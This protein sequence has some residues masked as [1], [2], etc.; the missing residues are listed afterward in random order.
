MFLIHVFY[1][2]I[3]ISNNTF[4]DNDNSKHNSINN[5]NIEINV[6]YSTEQRT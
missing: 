4:Y 1:W 5:N 2:A 6:S 3:N